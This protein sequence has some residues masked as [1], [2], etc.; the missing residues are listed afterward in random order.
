MC[1]VFLHFGSMFQN[2]NVCCLCSRQLCMY[3]CFI[4]PF[5]SVLQ[6]HILFRVLHMSFASYVSFFPLL[7]ESVKTNDC[8]F[9]Q[10]GS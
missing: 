4:L 2:H 5:V 6:K 7:I 10:T 9:S 1:A 3:V 8:A